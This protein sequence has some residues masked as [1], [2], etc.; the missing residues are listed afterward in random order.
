M[1]N[2]SP[3]TPEEAEAAI[4]ST[5]GSICSKLKAL[6]SVANLFAEWIGFIENDDGSL[7]DEGKEFFSSVAVPVGGIIFWPMD[8]APDGYLVANG[9]TVSRTTYSGLF[10]VYGTKYG[11]G[12]GSTTFVLPNMQRRFPFGAS[13][14]NVPGST[15]GAESVVLTIP[16]LPT[17]RPQLATGMDAFIMEDT[18]NG[19]D[20]IDGT[21]GNILRSDASEAFSEIGEDEPVDILNP[22]F[23]GHWIIKV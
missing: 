9:A 23:S 21:N 14:T 17:H 20:S 11:A 2:P 6:W 10:A 3:V 18:G 12:D 8:T 7:S 13:G 15:G 1:A 4:P 5:T 19:T 22:Y 16:N